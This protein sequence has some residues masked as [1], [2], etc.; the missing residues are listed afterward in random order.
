M[1]PPVTL[2]PCAVHYLGLQEAKATLVVPL[3]LRPVFS[4]DKQILA[5]H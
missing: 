1:V 2:V 4:S 3:G 5:I